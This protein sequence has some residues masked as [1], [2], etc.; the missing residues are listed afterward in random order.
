MR[1]EVTIHIPCLT[2]NHQSLQ[3][4]RENIV[5]AGAFPGGHLNVVEFVE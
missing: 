2:A 4:P 5:S 1:I 3:L